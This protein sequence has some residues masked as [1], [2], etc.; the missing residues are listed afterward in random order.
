MGPGDRD[1]ATL[2]GVEVIYRQGDEVVALFRR[3]GRGGFLVFADT[4]FF[5]DMNIEGESGFWIGNLALIH[6]TFQRYLGADPD[7]VTPLFRS[8]EKPQ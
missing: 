1:P 3:T 8:P 2:P 4:R 5:S 6:D 7:A